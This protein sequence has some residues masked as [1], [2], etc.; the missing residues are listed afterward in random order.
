MCV[1]L[2]KAY[3]FQHGLVRMNGRLKKR[4]S[5][6]GDRDEL[7][8][9]KQRS[10]TKLYHQVISTVTGLIQDLWNISHFSNR[11][12]FVGPKK[13]KA[14]DVASWTWMRVVGSDSER[15]GNP[16]CLF[17]ARGSFS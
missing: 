10:N 13:V 15:L 4:Q 2:H 12:I 14:R 11:T 7:H 8:T 9:E 1:C 5:V 16:A 6:T 3:Q 17:Q